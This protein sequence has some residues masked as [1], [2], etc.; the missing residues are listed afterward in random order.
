[1]LLLVVVVVVMVV[2]SGCDYSCCSWRHEVVQIANN[3][4]NDTT[5]SKS[6][7][8]VGEARAHAGEYSEVQGSCSGALSRTL[9]G[10]SK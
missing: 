3:D 4:N 7:E 2:V 1:M 8:G 6:L 5:N 9:L 10:S